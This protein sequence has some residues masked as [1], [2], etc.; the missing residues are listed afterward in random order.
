MHKYM[1]AIG[2]SKFNNFKEEQKLI[3]DIIVN[4][5]KRAYT[6]LS[7]DIIISH[8]GLQSGRNGL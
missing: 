5:S 3:T 1:R 8:T 6:S 2:F 7:D 4:A